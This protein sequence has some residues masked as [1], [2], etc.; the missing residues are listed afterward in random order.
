MFYKTI[1]LGRP[2]FYF[3]IFHLSFPHE[4]ELK[5]V[6]MSATLDGLVPRV[7]GDVVLFVRLEQV[8]RTHGVTACKDSLQTKRGRVFNFII[9][10][11]LQ[12]RSE[13]KYDHLI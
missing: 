4:P 9:P 12:R 3:F 5:D 10:G 2:F 13:T 1:I 11:T 6:H 7:I 8:T